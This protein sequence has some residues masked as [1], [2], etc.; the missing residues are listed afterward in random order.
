MGRRV[1]L[2]AVLALVLAASVP[3]GATADVRA[4]PETT[5]VSGPHSALTTLQDNSTETPDATPTSEPDGNDSGG[6]RPAGPTAA[7][8]V[9]I[10]PV[11]METD[12]SSVAVEEQGETYNTSGPFALF[13]VSEPVDQVAIQ[14]PKASATV[15]EGGRQI[16]VEYKSDAAPPGEQSLYTLELYWDDGSSRSVDLFAAQTDVQVGSSQMQQYRPLI[17]D[18]L[19]DAENKGYTRDPEG[20]RE[21]YEDQRET[22]QLLESLFAEQAARLFANLLG[23]AMN[24]LGIAATIAVAALIAYWQLRRNK[25]ALEF[26]TQD[27]GKAARLRERLW[28]QY[29]RDQQTAAEEPLKKLKGLS[30][31]DQIYWKNAFGVDTTAQLA[32]LFH[33][34]M[35]VRRDGEVQHVGGVSDLDPE[36]I[37]SSW[38]EAVCRDHR[39]PNVE[40]ALT[41]GKTAL[42]RMISEYGMGHRYE[43]T[44]ETTVELI[45]EL[46]ESRDLTRYAAE[47]R[48]RLGG[49][50]SAA[51]GGDD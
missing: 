23:I 20:A 8:T 4:T 16:L 43:E 37:H 38:L 6:A 26:L 11:Q 31:G 12:V 5:V 2:L 45:E 41:H 7:D 9:R 40:T 39:L 48:D 14:Q 22:A 28:L 25:D 49:G 13:S 24:P 10:L 34:G 27:S 50:T 32:E 29:E 18:I 46:D 35:A 33:Q 42:R 19:N 3:A 36:T 47:S 21:H 30:E 51:A 15:L 44:Y 17:L 1:L